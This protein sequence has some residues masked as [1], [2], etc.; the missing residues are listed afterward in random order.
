MAMGSALYYK[1][2]ALPKR[3]VSNRFEAV[4]LKFE[5]GVICFLLNLHGFSLSPL[6]QNM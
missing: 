4:Q 6:R 5:E 3:D 1:V 2:G